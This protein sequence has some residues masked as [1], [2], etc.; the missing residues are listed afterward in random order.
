[1]VRNKAREDWV[2]DGDSQRSY[3]LFDDQNFDFFDCTRVCAAQNGTIVTPWNADIVEFLETEV[4]PRRAPDPETPENPLSA[5]PRSRTFAYWVGATRS[6]RSLTRWHWM[7]AQG[8]GGKTASGT[9]GATIGCPAFPLN[10]A[11]E[12]SSSSS[13]TSS[14][15]RKEKEFAPLEWADWGP[16]QP[17]LYFGGLLKACAVAS[18]V[19]TDRPWVSLFLKTA[20]ESYVQGEGGDFSS[21]SEAKSP[22]L[23]DF[24]RL[25]WYD[26]PCGEKRAACLCQQPAEV[27]F[28]WVA[29]ERRLRAASSDL[30]RGD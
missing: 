10:A 18:T 14:H 17:E 25:A 4:L 12:F 13:S 15:S 3:R 8:A 16:G 27:P 21:P 22:S 24:T 2:F 28:N 19:P 6:M 26:V 29:H 23:V 11:E 30:G 20:H 1:M 5:Y 9:T 7:V